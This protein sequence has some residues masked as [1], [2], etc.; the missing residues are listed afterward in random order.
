MPI[1]CLVSVVILSIA[2]SS[3]DQGKLLKYASTIALGD[4]NP[5]GLYVRHDSIWI[6][7]SDHN[8]LHIVDL[9]GNSL[10]RSEGFER[11]MHIILDGDD[12]YVPSYGINAI[13]VTD[14][15]HKYD[16]LHIGQ[17]L[18]APAAIALHGEQKAIA[19]FYNHRVL[20][21]N[22][23][24]WIVIGSEGDSPKQFYYPTD[25]HFHNEELY[26]ADAYNNRVQV[27]SQTGEFLRI[28]GDQDDLNAATGILVNDRALYVTDFENDRVMVYSHAG[29]LIQIL[30]MNIL[31]PTDIVESEGV[32][33]IANYGN[34]TL[35][36]YR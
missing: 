10:V 12:V 27:F 28:I 3:C 23:A 16:T 31:K 34:K 33:Y 24:K 9:K 14:L 11:P 5:L 17:E 7:D 19:D 15:Q 29:K 18:D 30:D 36:V 25:V 20:L 4:I 1:L 32:F 35:A 22:G 6:A 2:L 13:I 8:N 21:Y 26:V